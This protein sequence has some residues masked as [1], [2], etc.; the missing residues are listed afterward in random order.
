MG[1]MYEQGLGLEQDYAQATSRYEKGVET[2]DLTSGHYLG[3]LYKQELGED[4]DYEKAAECS[5][6]PR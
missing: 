2:G 6:S 3:L 4:Q 1:M 5:A